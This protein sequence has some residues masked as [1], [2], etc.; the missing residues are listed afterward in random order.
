[1]VERVKEV[2]KSESL[3]V[4]ARIGLSNN[5]LSGGWRNSS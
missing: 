1:M 3:A 2:E 4:I 5:I